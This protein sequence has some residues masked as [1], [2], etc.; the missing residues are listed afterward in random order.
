MVT[1]YHH[2]LPET[3]QWIIQLGS[4]EVTRHNLSDLLSDG[5]VSLRAGGALKSP[6]V[7]A[8]RSSSWLPQLNHHLWYHTLFY[9]CLWDFLKYPD[10][11]RQI[12]WYHTPFRESNTT[13]HATKLAACE[14][15]C[16]GYINSYDANPCCIPTEGPNSPVWYSSGIFE[17]VLRIPLAVL[18][19][20]HRIC[21]C[22]SI[23]CFSKAERM[24]RMLV[25]RETSLEALHHLV[26]F[27]P[28][29]VIFSNSTTYFL[30]LFNLVR[31]HENRQPGR[32]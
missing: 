31:P 10:Q 8:D 2:R 27:C 22:E 1:P 19:L 17:I 23:F 6:Q 30:H 26:S 28:C 24:P 13:S 14:V 21:S 16:S 3:D 4:D 9:W 7:S 20:I 11:S 25:F 12:L 29:F 32:H 5:K 15:S 18:L